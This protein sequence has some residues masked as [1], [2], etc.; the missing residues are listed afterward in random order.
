MAVETQISDGCRPERVVELAAGVAG[1][2]AR[3]VA[4]HME[5]CAS[6]QQTLAQATQLLDAAADLRQRP[7]DHPRQDR[8]WQQ[9]IG[10]AQRSSRRMARRAAWRTVL[11]SP[12]ARV[13]AVAALLLVM[14][15][16]VV[17][18]RLGTGARRPEAAAQL[19]VSPRVNVKHPAPEAVVRRGAAPAAAAAPARRDVAWRRVA[20]ARSRPVV[21]R[22]A[23][24]GARRLACGA[25]L[26]DTAGSSRVTRDQP[27]QAEVR[28]DQGRVALQVPRLPRGG[29]LRV[30]TPDAVVLVKGTRFAVQRQ[31]GSTTVEVSRGAVL[32]QPVGR[33]RRSRL[34]S[35]GERWLVPGEAAYL[36]SLW[37][38][39]E[40]AV[41]RQDF[42]RAAARGR[43]YLAV[44]SQPARATSVRLRL[45]GALARLGRF[46][47]AAALYR[48]VSLGR[49]RPVA[50]ENAL[51]LLAGLHERRGRSRQALAV[52]RQLVA[53]FPRGAHARD[54]WM[55][56]VRAS[57]GEQTPAALSARAGLTACCAASSAAQAML[58]ACS[59][60]SGR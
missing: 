41:D 54:A 10:E 16:L 52:W 22:V 8:L 5:Q 18:N 56:L 26:R 15:A 21:S 47:E 23:S 33:N 39:M 28:L 40:Q 9:L 48:D 60:G 35:A 24:R 59:G 2:H 12:V 17:A 37:Q 30:V 43:R 49:G 45:A 42:V 34:L 51:A 55:R 1:A 3:G 6:C 29:Q 20:R 58:E 53:R 44:T 13:G 7:A 38:Q 4:L 14:L 46:G 27:L 31:G 25:L 19:E 32:V 57:C 11:G 50:R 36:R